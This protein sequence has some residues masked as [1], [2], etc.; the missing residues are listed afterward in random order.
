[1]V[2]PPFLEAF[3][4]SPQAKRLAVIGAQGGGRQTLPIQNLKLFLIPLPPYDEQ[5]RIVAVL[6]MQMAAIERARAAVNDQLE[7]SEKLSMTYLQSI[8]DNL[9]AQNWPEIRLGDVCEEITGT[10]NPFLIPNEPFYYVD[11]TSVDNHSKRITTPKI[12]LGKDAPSRARQVIKQRDVIVSTTRPNLN[13]VALVQPE[14][15]NQIC[16][17]GFCVLRPKENLDANYLFMFVQSPD[18][19][20]NLNDLVKGALYPAVTDKLVRSQF[21][22]LPPIPEQQRIAAILN[23]QLVLVKLINSSVEI[24][25]KTINEL[26]NVLLQRAFTGGL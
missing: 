25:S 20:N 12:L 19:V 11:I 13:A 15:D 3:L 1:L 9:R 5:Q 17:T 2:W 10:R 21:I 26:P 23:E 24:Q 4:N 8:F 14:L 16:S 7:I 6:N 18:F 22:P